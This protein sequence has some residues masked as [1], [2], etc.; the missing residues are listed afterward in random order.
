MSDRKKQIND[1]WQPRKH[2]WQPKTPN[3]ESE[4]PKPEGG[5]QPTT[6]EG[7]NPGNPPKEE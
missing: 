4:K 2:G 5:Y 1:G 7:E 3:S 6:S